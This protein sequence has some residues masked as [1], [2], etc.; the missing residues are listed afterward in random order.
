MLKLLEL[1]EKADT[2]CRIGISKLCT[3]KRAKVPLFI[4]ALTTPREILR[5]CL[6]LKSVLKKTFLRSLAEYCSSTEEKNF[7]KC[8]SSK[9]CSAFY[10]DFII[11]TGNT[12]VDVLKLCPSCKPPLS[13]I[14]E[15][16]TRL[17]PR[18]YSI[19]N[20]PLRTK[21]VITFIFS[22]LTTNPGVTTKMLKEKILEQNPSILTY[23]R[24]S[25][26][27][28]YTEDNYHQNQILIAIG[29]GLAPFLGFLEHKQQLMVKHKKQSPG[30]TW[31]FVGATT[32]TSI[33]HR[34]KL[35]M[36]LSENTLNNFV[37]SYSRSTTA[38]H[39][40]QDALEE[41]SKQLVELLMAPDTYLYLCADGGE[42]SKSIEN[43]LKNILC[44][45]LSITEADSDS[46]LK[47]FKTSRKYREDVWL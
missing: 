41:N 37:E 36:W 2:K 21:K 33:I 43:A 11:I 35:L 29:T 12:L 42:I 9:E 5:D 28:R 47:D 7:L 30:I 15:H 10:N 14:V 3:N 17:L 22:T 8:L 16:L 13:L 25:N 18:P 31:L 4:P 39:Y 44:K 32:Q 45:E 27:F 34:E 38:F 26:H 24:D 6:N 19:A 23:I 46:L 40:V 1:E 20:S